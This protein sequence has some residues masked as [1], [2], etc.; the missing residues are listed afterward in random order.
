MQLIATDDIG[1]FV[2]AIFADKAR[3]GGETLKIAGDTVS[4]RELEA[5]LTEAAG[6]PIA[7]ARFPDE[8]L[9]SNPDLQQMA[10][11]LDNG[12]LSERVD[13]N[14]MRE[15]NPGIVSFRSWLAKSGRKAFDEALGTKA[16]ETT[17]RHKNA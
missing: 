13:L 9:A 4:G 7:Y 3:Y 16:D 1:K 6:R 2:A 8:V 14:L 15:I 5:I 17:P 12:P 11:S 10:V